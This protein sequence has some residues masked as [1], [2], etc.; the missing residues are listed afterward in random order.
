MDRGDEMSVEIESAIEIIDVEN[1]HRGSLIP[2]LQKVQDKYGYLP[3][4]IIQLI[5]KKLDIPV[6][7][8]YGAATFY[9]QFRFQPQGKYV[10]RV[11][12]GTACHIAGAQKLTDVLA[13]ELGIRDGQTTS[14]GLFTLQR[15]ACL[16]CCSLAPVMMINETTYGRLTPSKLTKIINS[17]RKQEVEKTK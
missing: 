7:M 4:K 12:H 3:E 14:D 11:C 15:V 6:S 5:A 2:V 13:E 8:V 10:I 9:S 1:T 16:G 17:Y